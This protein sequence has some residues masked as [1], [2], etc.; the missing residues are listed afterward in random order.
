MNPVRLLR[1]I[2]MVRVLTATVNS[3]SIL[4]IQFKK[5]FFIETKYNPVLKKI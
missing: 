3:C 1:M 2:G 4:K 5:L